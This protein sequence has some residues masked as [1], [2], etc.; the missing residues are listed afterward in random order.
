MCGDLSLIVDPTLNGVG[1]IYHFNSGHS[2]GRADEA[3][4]GMVGVGWVWGGVE[5][6]AGSVGAGITGEAWLRKFDED[7]FTWTPCPVTI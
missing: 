3:G 6:G 2:R 7:V 4:A 1:S 5:N